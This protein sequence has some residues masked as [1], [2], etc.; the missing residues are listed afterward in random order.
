MISSNI[1]DL[2]KGHMIME[3]NESEQRTGTETFTIFRFCFTEAPV[4]SRSVYIRQWATDD[5][6]LK[7]ETRA[8]YIII[9]IIIIIIIFGCANP[10]LE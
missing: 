6:W 7:L 3:L 5:Q 10:E 9:I 2:Q 8:E 1:A 4:N